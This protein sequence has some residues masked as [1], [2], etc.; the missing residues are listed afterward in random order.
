MLNALAQ[1][2]LSCR[3][4]E[5]KD[6]SKALELAQRACALTQSKEPE[7]LSTLAVAYATLN[8]LSKAVDILENALVLAQAKGDQALLAKIRKQL[9]LIKRAMAELY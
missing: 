2:V 1:A 7:Y 5:L 8:N 6:P 4:P 3:N 9:S